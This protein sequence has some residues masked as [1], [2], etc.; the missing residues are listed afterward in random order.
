[1]F[2]EFPLFSDRLWAGGGRPLGLPS[3]SGDAEVDMNSLS[4]YPNVLVNVSRTPWILID[5]EK[6]PDLAGN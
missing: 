4:T 3:V 5:Y 6:S 2:F 1:M